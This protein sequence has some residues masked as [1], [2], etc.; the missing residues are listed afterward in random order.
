L[1][2]LA[3]LGLGATVSGRSVLNSERDVRT[4]VPKTPEVA[5][6]TPTPETLLSTEE[7]VQREIGECKDIIQNERYE[8]IIKN[9]YLVS[10]LYYS[11]ECLNTL[12]LDPG[13]PSEII[14]RIYPLITRA[15]RERYLQR[16]HADILKRIITENQTGEIISSTESSPLDSIS[17]GANLRDN[18]QDAI[19][20]FVEEGSP[21]RSM[22]G[23]I[24]V[25]S[26]NGWEKDDQLSTSSTRG[27]NTV[28]VFNPQ[29]QSFYRYAHMKETKVVTG[30]IVSAGEEIGVVGNSGI[31][32][33]KAGHGKHLHLEI[34][35]YDKASGKMVAMDV[36]TLLKKLETI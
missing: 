21:I 18:H 36:F 2:T 24:V 4:P 17:A 29:N 3:V 26:E 9:P 13:S 27:G 16:L 11:E 5:P 20:L 12:D 30:A 28:I 34:N 31:N 8:D 23:G 1:K 14:L 6:I 15:F 7:I 35:N 10:A 32:A 22:S 19:D 25:L 33:S